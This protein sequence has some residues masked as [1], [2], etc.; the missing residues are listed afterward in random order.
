MI[1]RSMVLFKYKRKMLISLASRSGHYSIS[2][3]AR[4]NRT[5]IQ[6]S[7]NFRVWFYPH[8]T[9]YGLGEDMMTD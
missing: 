1:R 4:E 8:G 2:M 7:G 3:I 6:D 5:E 9:M